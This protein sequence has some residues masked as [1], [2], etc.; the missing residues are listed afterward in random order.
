MPMLLHSRVVERRTGRVGARSGAGGRERGREGAVINLAAVPHLGASL[1]S[2]KLAVARSKAR[3]T[4]GRARADGKRE[5]KPQKAEE[6]V[7]LLSNLIRPAPLLS[8]SSIST[9]FSFEG[10][11]AESVLPRRNFSR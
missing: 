4:D 5:R 2:A 9:S 3:V 8:P 6:N 10:E 1:P 11:C 7:C